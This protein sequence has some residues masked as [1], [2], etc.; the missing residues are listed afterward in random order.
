MIDQPPNPSEQALLESLT[1]EQLQL[2]ANWLDVEKLIR[3]EEGYGHSDLT[4]SLT[5]MS[6]KLRTLVQTQQPPN[7]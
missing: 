2:V 7:V 3:I 5:W 1:P 4:W 6:H